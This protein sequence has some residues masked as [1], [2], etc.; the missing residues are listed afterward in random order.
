MCPKSADG[1][2]G[3]HDDVRPLVAADLRRVTEIDRAITGQS[4]RGFFAN[5]FDALSK[6]PG[7]LV[8]LGYPRHDPLQGFLLAQILD[9]EFGGRFPVATMDA[10]GVAPGARHQGIGRALL[11]A[12]D[13]QLRQRGV[14]ELRTEAEWTADALLRLF[15]TAGFRLAPRYVLERPTDVPVPMI[16]RA[17][18]EDT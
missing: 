16:G 6:H 5:R 15:A 17:A 2:A 18:M 3:R 13:T 12:L 7:A 9:G 8:A 1:P 11:A 14:R 4:R 10:I